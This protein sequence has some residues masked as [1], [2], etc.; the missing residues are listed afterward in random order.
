MIGKL[1]TYLSGFATGFILSQYYGPVKEVTNILQKVPGFQGLGM[2]QQARDLVAKAQ[3]GGVSGAVAQGGGGM[4]P[5]LP[6]IADIKQVTQAMVNR[7]EN[8]IQA[9]LPDSTG[10]KPAAP[11]P[12]QQ[13]EQ[14]KGVLGFS[15]PSM[16]SLNRVDPNGL[17]EPE[18]RLREFIGTNN[19]FWTQAPPYAS[20]AWDENLASQ[21]LGHQYIGQMTYEL[22][23]G[24]AQSF[25]YDLGI[26]TSNLKGAPSN[27]V[28]LQR[29]SPAGQNLGSWSKSFTGELLGTDSAAH[30][31]NVVIPN[32][33]PGHEREASHLAFKLKSGIAARGE[34]TADLYALNGGSEW[35][36]VGKAKFTRLK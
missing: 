33:V 15:E 4:A 17:P 24:E 9:Q 1:I 8:A 28:R 30:A 23:P 18:R 26:A 21:F 22:R 6:S 13:Q 10:S 12:E 14:Q 25:S 35:R 16:G 36:K 5:G 19:E 11:A 27:Q 2:L 3:Q 31:L 34:V 7:S 20:K 29:K 32:M